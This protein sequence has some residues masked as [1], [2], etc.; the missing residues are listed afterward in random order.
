MSSGTRVS[1]RGRPACCGGCW[2]LT[3]GSTAQEAKAYFGDL[4]KHVVEFSPSSRDDDLLD[5]AFAKGRAADRRRWLQAFSAQPPHAH[6]P[7]GGHVTFA[8]F[9]EQELVQYSWH[10]VE[11]SIPSAIDGLK[12]SQRKVLHASFLR[13]GRRGASERDEV[14]VVQLAG[15]VAESTAYHHGEA[16][17][18]ATIVGMAQDF[19]GANNAPLLVPAGQFGTRAEGGKDAA[20]PRYIFTRLHRNARLFFPKPDDALLPPR[21]EDG[22]PVEPQSFVPVVPTVLINGAQGIGTGWS[23]CVGVW[24][25]RAR[26]WLTLDADSCLLT[27]RSM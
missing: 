26:G 3:S 14:K 10:D 21:L 25:A 12:P 15:F 8:E 23:S 24:R 6:E 27:I 17:L 16:S 7:A 20:A 11:R 4:G 18:H 19:V 13:A 22:Q 1:A 5:M 9:V 2:Q